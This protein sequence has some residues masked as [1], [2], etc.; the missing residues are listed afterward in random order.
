MVLILAANRTSR[1]SVKARRAQVQHKERAL[2]RMIPLLVRASFDISTENSHSATQART[3]EVRRTQMR[4]S[5]A[6]HPLYTMNMTL[7]LPMNRRGSVYAPTSRSLTCLHSMQRPSQ[8]RSFCRRAHVRS[9]AILR[10]PCCQCRIRFV[11]FS[12]HLDFCLPNDSTQQ[13]TTRLCCE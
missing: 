10:A 3:M 12:I 6:S 4:R 8:V 9:H 13:P 1:R 11:C 5:L 7:G 2:P